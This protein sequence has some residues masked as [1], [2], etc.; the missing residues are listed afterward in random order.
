[1]NQC[2]RLFVLLCVAMMLHVT[3]LRAADRP[4]VLFIAIDD[5]NHWAK[6]VMGKRRQEPSN[7]QA[8]AIRPG[9]WHVMTKTISSWRLGLS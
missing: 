9:V 7:R 1:M 3:S 4:N 5:L 2:L 6:G 8:C